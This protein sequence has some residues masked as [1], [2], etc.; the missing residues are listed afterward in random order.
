MKH[1]KAM[2][3]GLT[4]AVLAASPAAARADDEREDLDV[5]M[6]VLDSASDFDELMAE[7]PGP[8]DED[9]DDEDWE[10][11]TEPE[12]QESDEDLEDQDGFEDELEEDFEDEFEHGDEEEPEDE[13]ERE[14]DFEDG[15]DIDEDEF[16]E[17]D[18]E[19]EDEEPLED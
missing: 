10:N 15:E 18:D 16:D 7:M 9:V 12:Q 1:L 14:D 11:G 2:F 13:M 4:L 6:M 17:E 3:A 8:A 5:T 19:E